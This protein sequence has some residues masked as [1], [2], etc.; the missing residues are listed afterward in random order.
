MLFDTKTFF[1]LSL[2]KL[3]NKLECLSLE[4]VLMLVKHLQVSVY[5]PHVGMQPALPANII[6]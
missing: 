6:L 4:R 3:P 2:V 5:P 1:S